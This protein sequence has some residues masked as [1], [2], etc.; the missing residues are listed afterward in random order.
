MGDDHDRSPVERQVAACRQIAAG[1]GWVI[2]RVYEDVASS[3]VPRP[4][5]D[6]MLADIRSRVIDGVIVYD[7]DRLTRSAAEHARFADLVDRHRV[8]VVTAGPRS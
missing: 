5:Y 2:E 8:A 6:R 3:G 1:E 4:G 7:L